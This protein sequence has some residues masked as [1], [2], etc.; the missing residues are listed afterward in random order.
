MS[1]HNFYSHEEIHGQYISLGL[2]LD[3]I[4]KNEKSIKNFFE[5]PGDIVFL[6][7]GSSYWMSLSAHKTM[8]LFTGRRTFAV[9]AGEIV[10]CPDEFI[11]LFESPMIL[12]PSRSGLT[13]EC[14]EAIDILIEAYPSARILSVTEY[15]ENKLMERSDLHLSIGWANERSVCQTRSFSNLY[16]AFITIAAIVGERKGFIKQLRNYLA[17]APALYAMHENDIKSIISENQITSLVTLGSGLQYGVAIEGAYIVIEMAEFSSNYYQ[18]LEYRHGPIVTAGKG[19]A[20]FICANGQLQETESKLAA[21]IRETG[22]CVY[23]V[24][25]SPQDWA[26]HTFSL[27]SEYAKEIVSLHFVFVLQSFAYHFSIARMK[28]PDKPGNLTP[29]ISYK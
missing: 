3:Y 19:T 13:Q 20:V 18:L 5:Q 7:S 15:T 23:L 26:D 22:A 16:L 1:N 12:V 6:A 2:T 25:C 14:L 24:T 28:N 11:K 27:E 10:M 4:L 9:M 17:H 8:H 21:E 29:F